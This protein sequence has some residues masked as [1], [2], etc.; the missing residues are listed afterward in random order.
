[1]IKRLSVAL[2]VGAGRVDEDQSDID[3]DRL[4]PALRRTLLSTKHS[5]AQ[6]GEREEDHG[7]EK[8]RFFIRLNTITDRRHRDR[9]RPGRR[10]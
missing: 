4:I 1:M 10:D 8:A 2:R 5:R 3:F 9:L 6:E 7:E